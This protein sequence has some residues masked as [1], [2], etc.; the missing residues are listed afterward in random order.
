MRRVFIPLLI[1]L[2]SLCGQAIAAP[3][4]SLNSTSAP[5]TAVQP[6]VISEKECPDLRIYT[7]GGGELFK[8][9][10]NTISLLIYGNASN[11]EIAK[12]FNAILRLAMAI[13]AFC[14]AY[15]AFS[16]ESFVPIFR[17]FFLPSL[18]ISGLLI[19]P[20]S[21]V[22]IHDLL[23]SKVPDTKAYTIR[24]V[25]NAPFF[26]V[27]VCTMISTLSYHITHSLESVSHGVDSPTYNWTGH[28]YAGDSLL[29]SNKMRITDRTL[30]DNFREFCRECA[31]RDIGIG[32]YSKDDLVTSQNLMQ[33]LEDNTSRIRTMFYR[34][35]DSGSDKNGKALRGA[36]SKAV[37][38]HEA[39]Q[40]INQKLQG[41]DISSKQIA[42]G[43]LGSEFTYLMGQS[44]KGS[45]NLSNLIKQQIAIQTLG[46][47]LPG[48]FE[49]FAVKRAEAHQRENQK[50]LGALGAKSIVAMRNFFEAIV[51]MVFP[52][53]IIM[54]LASFGVSALSNWIQ[55]VLWVNLWP[56]FYVVINFLLDSIWHFKRHLIPGD[57]STLT[58]SSSEG[59]CNLYE[60]MESIAAIALAFVPY[61]SWVLMKGGVSQMVHLASSLMGPAQSAAGQAASESTSGSYSFGNVSMGNASAHNHDAFRQS[62]S[63]HLSR[64]SV[65]LDEGAG[66]MTYAEG[67]DQMF[68][69]QS[70][71]YL[72]EG[73]TKS[74][75]F[76]RAVQNQRS[77]ADMAVKEESLATSNSITETANKAVGFVDSLSKN[78]NQGNSLNAQSSS[79]MQEMF[80]NA[81][82]IADDY[83]KTYGMSRD[84]A[85]REMAEIGLGGGAFGFKAGGSASINEGATKTE[86]DSLSER[87][88][89]SN[90]FMEQLQVAKNWSSAELSSEMNSQDLRAH[91]DFVNS[92]NK[93]E[94]QTNQL[95]AAQSHQESLSRVDS[96]ASSENLAIQQNLNQKYVDFLRDEFDGD[97]GKVSQAVEG[98]YSEESGQHLLSKFVSEYLPK[99]LPDQTVATSYESFKSELPSGL[100]ERVSPRIEEGNEMSSGHLGGLNSKS[101]ILNSREELQSQITSHERGSQEELRSNKKVAN[102]KSGQMKVSAVS[103]TKEQTVRKAAAEHGVYSA[104]ILGKVEN[105]FNEPRKIKSSPSWIQVNKQMQNPES[106]W[107]NRE[108]D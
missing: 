43:E 45:S 64:G 34:E 8:K 28:I 39:I 46:E 16:K 80:H 75:S 27:K 56:P 100:S 95:R 48:S 91:E 89:M 92:W 83:A 106:H 26:M 41:A 105:F 49:G 69:R 66:T 29:Q 52:L 57:S 42:L 32:L 85:V 98:S 65:T 90:Q 68:L 20:R 79:H 94:S 96:W 60:S 103:T 73:I 62:F 87:A 93:T 99:E 59:L 44:Q 104:K 101:S 2:F 10:F 40:T 102:E 33:F 35:K 108:K 54:S 47:E 36:H 81:T 71:S 19:V 67:S 63:G 37:T 77:S 53:M 82:S 38:C 23:D 61:L 3:Q 22:F 7:F 14:A 72:R 9:V 76:N 30:E 13:G 50:I 6:K 15:T 74:D 58:V 25:S 107:E 78:I 31:W 18:A 21:D 1:A 4:S 24:K 84:S 12:S 11:G 70:D 88:S 97:M 55:F 17:S 51:Y 5:Q 86:G